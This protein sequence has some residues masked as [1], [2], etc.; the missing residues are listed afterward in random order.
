MTRFF[1]LALMLSQ[2]ATAQNPS[3]ALDGQTIPLWQGAAPGALGA[4]EADVPSLTIFL[5]R[6]LAPNTPAVVI[7]PGGSY[8]RLA[9]NHE[10]RQVA[11]F[12][13]SLGF[14]AY[15]LRYRLGSR[16]GTVIPMAPSANAT[17]TPPPTATAR[18]LKPF[19]L[20]AASP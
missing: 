3:T 19:P 6:T 14:A 5:P 17:A 4:D 1:L 11:N 16:R 8:A 9:S 12:F 2:S 13:N 7:A 10:G 15:V 20:I 18:R